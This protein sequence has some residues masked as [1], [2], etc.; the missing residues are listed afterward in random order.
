MSCW[1]WAVLCSAAASLIKTW[2]QVAA[3]WRTS[4]HVGCVQ[5]YRTLLVHADVQMVKAIHYVG[6]LAAYLSGSK[7][8]IEGLH[9]IRA[10]GLHQ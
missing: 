1:S 2:M 3:G 4:S 9:S 8:G 7:V 10:R 6:D 5:M